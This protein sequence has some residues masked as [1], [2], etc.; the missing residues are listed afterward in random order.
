MKVL[1]IIDV[2]NDFLINGSLEV[3]DGNDVIEPINEI[4]KNYALVVATKDWHPLDHVSFVSNHQGK[5]IGDVV[6]V[7]NLDQILWPVHCV[8]ESRGSD[9]PTTLN[10]K[11]INKIIYKG[12]N[13][14]IDSYSGFHDNGKIRST[15]LSDYLKA[16]NITSIDYVGL[17][18]EYCVKFTVFDSIKEGFR[19][20]VILKGIKGINLEESNKAL[21]EMRS[22]GIDLL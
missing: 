10:I 12:T 4:I 7:N 21:K 22:K 19:S 14:Q 11:A 3:P 8:Q 6:K 5:K 17:V 16:K 18:T 15:G 1:V 2:Q 13:S 9:F 20:R